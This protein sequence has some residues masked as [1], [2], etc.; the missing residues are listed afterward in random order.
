MS[1]VIFL[2]IDGVLNS[3][4]WEQEVLNTYGI[5]AVTILD[6]KALFLLTELV[7]WTNARLVL[8]SS[9][10]ISAFAREAV[11]DNLRPYGLSLY[12]WTEQET[13]CRG[14]QIEAWLAKHPEVTKFVILDDDNDMGNL[15]DHLVQTTFYNGLQLKHINMAYDILTEGEKNYAN[16]N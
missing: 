5:D 16:E 15:M 6:Q 9:W 3:A 2:D 1:K 10:R 14:D 12:S 7:N 13:G 11:Q 8:S 4:K